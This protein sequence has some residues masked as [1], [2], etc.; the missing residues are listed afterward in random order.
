MTKRELKNQIKS[1]KDTLTLIL[2]YPDSFH[3]AL[4]KRGTD[5][6][7]DKILDELNYFLN[8]LNEI[9]KNEERRN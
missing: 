6:L 4:G 5:E 2:N 8:E 1:R 7:V 3:Q 9:E